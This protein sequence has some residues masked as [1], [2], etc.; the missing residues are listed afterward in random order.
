MTGDQEPGALHPIE[1]TRPQGFLE[2]VVQVF[3]D[4]FK[5]IGKALMDGF[6]CVVEILQHAGIT[7]DDLREMQAIRE[8][9]RYWKDT[10]NRVRRTAGRESLIHNGRKPR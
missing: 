5:P 2:G 9:C 8:G 10:R 4:A 7:Q 3:V 1:P 6:R